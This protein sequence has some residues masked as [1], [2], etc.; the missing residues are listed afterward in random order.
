MASQH[1]GPRHVLGAT[2]VA[3]AAGGSSAFAAGGFS[4][5]PGPARASW[6]GSKRSTAEGEPSRGKT[7]AGLELRARRAKAG[8]PPWRAPG[9]ARGRGVAERGGRSFVLCCALTRV[10]PK[11]GKKKNSTLRRLPP[12]ETPHARIPPHP[13]APSPHTL[14]RASAAPSPPSSRTW[15][16][17]SPAGIEPRR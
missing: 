10:L 16:A 11:K 8:R 2:P 4:S 9:P 5:R 15:T 12:L 7:P 6:R 1:G 14:A 17:I 3:F 13:L